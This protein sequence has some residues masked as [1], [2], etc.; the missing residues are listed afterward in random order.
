M[1]GLPLTSS[2]SPTV[3]ALEGEDPEAKAE[4]ASATETRKYIADQSR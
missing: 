1:E 3:M 4:A 2:S